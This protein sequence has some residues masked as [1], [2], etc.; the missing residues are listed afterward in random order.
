VSYTPSEGGSPPERTD[1]ITAS[2]GGDSSNSPR[3]GTTTVTVLLITQLASGS[4]VIGDQNPSV[5]SSV[6]FW[7]SVTFL[8][9]QWWKRNSLSSGP[10]PSSF[11]GFASHTPNNPPRCGDRWTTEPGNSSNPPATVP[12]FMAVIA[13]SL[14]TQSGSTIAGNAPEV[15]IVKTNPGYQPSVGHLGTGTVVAVACH[16]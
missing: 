13:S 12:S 9:D 7:S 11:D 6:T 5:G 1:T 8:G 3:G 2:Y 16:N 4:F 14:V 10:V 15:V